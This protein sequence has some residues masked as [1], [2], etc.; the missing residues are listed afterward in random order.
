MTKERFEELIRTNGLVEYACYVGNYYG[1]P[2]EYVD[3]QRTLGKDVLLEIEIQGALKI[4]ET[5]PEAILIFIAP[6]DAE[7]GVARTIF[8][9]VLGEETP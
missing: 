4:R 7:D 2:R 6:P 3:R 5:Y 1:T 9:R 8:E